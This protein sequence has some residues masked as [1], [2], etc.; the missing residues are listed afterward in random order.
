MV[1]TGFIRLFERLWGL[2]PPVVAGIVIP[3]G[4]GPACQRLALAGGDKSRPYFVH[5]TNNV[6]AQ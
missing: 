2:P 3:G 4:R 6:I 1:S 5:Y